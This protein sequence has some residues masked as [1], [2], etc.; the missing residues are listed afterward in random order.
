M[1]K[2]ENELKIRSS[3]CACVRVYEK[4]V[5]IYIF[6]KRNK[7][8]CRILR[9]SKRNNLINKQRINYM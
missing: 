3:V 9:E 7:E 1:I 2:F 6:T 5:C 8:T 4:V